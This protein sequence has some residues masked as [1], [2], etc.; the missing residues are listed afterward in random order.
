MRVEQRIGRCDR[1][2]QTSDK[3]YVG[4]LASVGTIE[5]RILLRLYERLHVFERALG[6]LEVV[7]GEV[8]AAFERDLFRRGL[9][10]R[11]QDERLE[12]AAQA[13]EN[14][15]RHRQSIS[16]RASSPTRDANL[17][18]PSSRTSRR[19]RPGSCP[20]KNWPSSHTPALNATYRTPCSHEPFRKSSK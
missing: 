9:T 17:S 12:Q 1:L 3:V 20:H 6:E 14:N 18:T 15:E 19:P 7:L 10:Q 5:A 13:I 16:H 4:N 8:I 2:G 11:Q